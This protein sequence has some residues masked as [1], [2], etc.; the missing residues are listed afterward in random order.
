MFFHDNAHNDSWNSYFRDA[1]P[2]RCFDLSSSNGWKFAY[3][4]IKLL[5][6][7]A[8]FYHAY[9]YYKLCATDLI[10]NTVDISQHNFLLHSKFEVFFILYF[11]YFQFVLV[12]ILSNAIP[13]LEIL[14]HVHVLDLIHSKLSCS[15]VHGKYIRCLDGWMLMFSN[16]HDISLRQ[17]RQKIG[18]A[19]C[20]E[21]V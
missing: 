10:F 2:K 4:W 17:N 3:G 20:R 13:A 12:L 14:P 15:K 5:T 9:V 6:N 18:R 8:L 19:S 21:R 11:N 7:D 16:Y 1:A